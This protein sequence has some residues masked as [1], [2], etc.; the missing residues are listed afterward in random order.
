MFRSIM[1]VQFGE[2]ACQWVACQGAVHPRR[3]TQNTFDIF[4][5]QNE[6]S[7]HINNEVKFKKAIILDNQ[8]SCL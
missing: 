6:T 5:W 3:Y 8:H 1:L 2:V 7:Q 4:F